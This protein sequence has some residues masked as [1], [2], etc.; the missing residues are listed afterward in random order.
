MS[1]SQSSSQTTD[2]FQPSL[3]DLNDDSSSSS[4]S[5]SI[6]VDINV[7]SEEDVEPLEDIVSE[8]SKPGRGPKKTCPRLF[9][10]LKKGGDENGVTKKRKSVSVLRNKLSFY[11]RGKP[12]TSI[13]TLHKL[14]KQLCTIA[15]DE[16]MIDSIPWLREDKNRRVYGKTELNDV[17]TMK[18]GKHGKSITNGAEFTANIGFSLEALEALNNAHDYYM[19]TLFQRSKT[20]AYGANVNVKHD[21]SPLISHHHM[22][23]AHNI[24]ASSMGP[25]WHLRLAHKN[26]KL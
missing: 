22:L 6:D 5:G 18:D 1:G 17:K 2:Q 9:S 26:N 10:A 24:T 21:G 16:G 20:I 14:A 25:K 15:Y 13:H 12:S 23:L 7:F 4:T 3:S 8:K 11:Q 19:G